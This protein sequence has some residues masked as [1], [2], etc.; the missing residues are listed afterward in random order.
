MVANFLIS[1][2]ERTHVIDESDE[3]NENLEELTKTLGKKYK[4]SKKKI[5]KLE[6]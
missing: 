3:E 1:S 2:A 5:E 4:Y 6:Q